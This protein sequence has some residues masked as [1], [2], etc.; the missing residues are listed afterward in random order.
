M[1]CACVIRWCMQQA[2]R[3]GSTCARLCVW[4]QPPLAHPCLCIAHC[5]SW[6]FDMPCPMQITAHRK[7]SVSH[8]GLLFPRVGAAHRVC[9]LPVCRTHGDMVTSPMCDSP[10]EDPMLYIQSSL[11]Q[12]GRARL[13]THR[14]CGGGFDPQDLSPTNEGSHTPGRSSARSRRLSRTHLR[15]CR[16]SAIPSFPSWPPVGSRRWFGSGLQARTTRTPRKGSEAQA[17]HSRRWSHR[18]RTG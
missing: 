8:S 14:P 16:C 2:K 11:V 3:H 9:V 1:R 6:G 7:H 12:C 4:A 17:A 15:A 5:A 10:G 13:Q 18:T